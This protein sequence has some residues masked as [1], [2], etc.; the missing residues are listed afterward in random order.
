MRP[1][2]ATR[3]R[4]PGTATEPEAVRD[5]RTGAG[6][7]GRTRVT[8]RPSRRKPRGSS[9]NTRCLPKR[10][11]RVTVPAS[12]R[13]TAPQNPVP[14][15]STTRPG[16]AATSGAGFCFFHGGVRSA[17]YERGR[18]P[19]GPP[20]EGWWRETGG[21]IRMTIGEAGTQVSRHAEAA[22]QLV[23][24]PAHERRVHHRSVTGHVHRVLAAQ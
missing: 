21:R 9:G 2:R 5:A 15:S 8:T 7:E 6:E 10:S 14:G 18:G 13:I 12:Q 23:T 3:A 4:A 17:E 16:S 22:G 24:L 1:A 19:E 11:S 20:S